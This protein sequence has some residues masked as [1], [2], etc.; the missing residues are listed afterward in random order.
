MAL[1]PLLVENTCDPSR[2]CF[3]VYHS[4]SV[5]W[6]LLFIR[7]CSLLYGHTSMPYVL[8]NCPVTYATTGQT[9]A[10]A[11]SPALRSLSGEG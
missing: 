10:G 1:D 7:D 5:I 4:I 3:G 6:M 9:T 8:P 11:M 2:T